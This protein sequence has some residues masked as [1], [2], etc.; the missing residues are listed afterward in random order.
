MAYKT[1]RF[2]VAVLSLN[3]SEKRSLYWG[4]RSVEV[5]EEALASA[6]LRQL[7]QR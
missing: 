7:R 6:V 3:R 4:T 1:T 2:M 5:G